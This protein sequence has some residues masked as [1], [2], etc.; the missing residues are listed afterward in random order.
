[1][2]DAFARSVDRMIIFLR[3]RVGTKN[4]ELLF[5]AIIICAALLTLFLNVGAGIF[6]FVD[7]LSESLL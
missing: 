7:T 3:D 2:S 5:L 4:L 6:R 1:M